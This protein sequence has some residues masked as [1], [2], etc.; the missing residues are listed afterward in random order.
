MV[1]GPLFTAQQTARDCRRML[2]AGRADAL[3]SISADTTVTVEELRE[4]FKN[5]PL[6]TI[7]QLFKPEES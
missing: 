2:I 3:K 5:I 7:L 4:R 1:A 6:L